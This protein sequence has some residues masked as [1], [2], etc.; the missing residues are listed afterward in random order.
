MRWNEILNEAIIYADKRTDKKLYQ[1]TCLYDRGKLSKYIYLADQGKVPGIGAYKYE[2]KDDSLTKENLYP[3]SNTTL[4]VDHNNKIINLNVDFF[5]QRS[6]RPAKNN[7]HKSYTIPGA[8]IG[9]R[10][11]PLLLKKVLIDIM[12]FDPD[13]KNFIISSPSDFDGVSVERFINMQSPS[14]NISSKTTGII[15]LYHGT[16]MK[17][18]DEIKIKGLRPNMTPEIYGDLVTG[19]SEYNIYLSV[20]IAEARNYASRAAVDD[21]SLAVVLEVEINDFTKFVPDEDTLHWIEYAIGHNVKLKNYFI[22]KY[23]ENKFNNT[24]FKHWKWTDSEMTPFKMDLLKLYLTTIH[25]GITNTGTI[26]YKGS[27]KPS[28][29]KMIESYKPTSMKRD[30]SEDEF[31]SATE[32]TLATFKKY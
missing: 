31:Q 21:E 9:F 17:R 7:D 8:D 24:H 22:S 20:S 27:V 2:L 25:K 18:Y 23:G 4:T 13:V 16:S 28:K 26:A 30:P 12:K 5:Q 10:N 29:I 14:E 11:N 32:K 15:K 19:Y 6:R 3:L 1:V